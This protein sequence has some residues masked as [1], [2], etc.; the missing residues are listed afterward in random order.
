MTCTE[1]YLRMPEPWMWYESI[2]YTASYCTKMHRHS[3]WQL[4][5]SLEGTFRFRM[6][7]DE[8]LLP[9]GD[10]LLLSP[11]LLHD[12]GSDSP[13]SRAMQIFF[14]R[15]PHDLLPEPARR[16][17]LRRGIFRTGHGDREEFRR[18]AE[19]FLKKAPDT[20]PLGRSWRGVLGLEF[21]MTALETLRETPE[22]RREILPGIVRALEFMEE[23]FRR[24]ARHRGLRRRG[25]NC[26][27]AVSP[28][29][30]NAKPER[31][32]CFFSI[33]SVSA[34]HRVF[35]ST[36]FRSMRAAK[37]AGFSSPQYF[38]RYFRKRIGVLPRNLPRE[39]PSDIDGEKKIM[40]LKRI[41][42]AETGPGETS[43]PPSGAASSSRER[44][45]RPS[46]VSA[47]NWESRRSRCRRAVRELTEE[48]ILEVRR[49]AGIYAAG[50]L[51]EKLLRGC[52]AR[53]RPRGKTLYFFFPTLQSSGSYHASILCTIRQEAEKR[54]WNLRVQLLSP[55][56]YESAAGDP[57]AAGIVCT[58][59]PYP[60]PPA[61][62][63][64]IH[65]GMSGCGEIPAVTPDNYAAG[66]AADFI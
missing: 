37:Q 15:F 61:R 55:E 6:E 48:G 10:W 32:R 57:D 65:Y 40:K 21:A 25:G 5:A 39:P 35:F 19:K 38:C 11:E 36:D 43:G 33:R 42:L 51:P 54:A 44:E 4:T 7:D 8:I 12:A 27:K 45:Y 31:R 23:T 28:P 50:K 41:H 17:N 9:P 26:R 56:Q 59:P 62:V 34:T 64:V 1:I 46:A 53:S 63:P 22:E 66:F 47:L 2:T 29:F 30:S 16:F 24:T 13:R 60:L 49:G 3:A 14:R 52:R 58:T 18:I 20:A